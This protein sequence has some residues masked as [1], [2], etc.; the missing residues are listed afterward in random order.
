MKHLNEMVIFQKI[1]DEDIVYLIRAL[2][3]ELIARNEYVRQKY[4]EQIHFRDDNC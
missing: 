1:S 2:N 4:E 3:T